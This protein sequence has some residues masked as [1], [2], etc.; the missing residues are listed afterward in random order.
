MLVVL[1][2]LTPANAAT[3]TV[4]GSGCDYNKVST[5]IAGVNAGDELDITDTG[6]YADDLAISK[7]ITIKGTGASKPKVSGKVTITAG[8][9]TLQFITFDP[10]AN[11][12]AITVSG[13]STTLH[14]HDSAVSNGGGSSG[15]NTPIGAGINSTA[16]TL[17]ISN[18]TFT[19]NICSTNVDDKGAHLYANGGSVTIS[20]STFQQAQAEYGAAI[21]LTG[22]ITGAI[23]TSTFA[24]NVAGVEAASIWCDATGTLTLT[25]DIFQSGTS[26]TD[27]AGHVF[28]SSAI[29]LTIDNATVDATAGSSIT[30]AVAGGFLRRTSSSGVTTV[31]G[32]TFRD[33]T[34]PKNGGAFNV[35]GGSDLDISGATF[36]TD[37]ASADGGDIWFSGGTLTIASSTFAGYASSTVDAANGGAILLSGATADISGSSFTNFDASASGG[38]IRA[39]SSSVITLTDTTFTSNHAGGDGGAISLV[40]SD[41]SGSG[42]TF[43]SNLADANGGAIHTNPG[44]VDLVDSL[45][46][47]NDGDAGGAVYITADTVARFVRDDFCENVASNGNGGA[48]AVAGNKAFT[49]VFRYST[50]VDNDVTKASAQGGAL[51]LAT[52]TPQLVGLDLVGN[53]TPSNGSGGGAYIGTGNNTTITDTLVAYNTGGP[54]LTITGT[55]SA[56]YLGFYNTPATNASPAALTSSLGSFVADPRLVAYTNGDGCAALAGDLWPD[57]PGSPLIDAGDPAILDPDGTRADIGT[58]GGAVAEARPEPWVD[59]DNDGWPL[60]SDCDDA[61]AGSFP[62]AMYPDTDGDG[63]GDDGA[64]ADFGCSGTPGYVADHTDCDD[65]KAAVNPNATE[66]CDASNTDEDCDGLADDASAT[67]KTTFYRDQDGDTYGLTGTTQ[68]ACD[69]PAGYVATSGDCNDGSA[70]IHPGATETCNGSDDDCDGQTDESDA[71]DA[72]TWHQDSDGDGF[73]GTVTQ[74]ACNRPSGYVADATDC[75]DTNAARNTG[76]PELCSTAFDDDCNGQI[77]EATA[78]D[79]PTWYKDLDNDTYGT[80][81]NTRVQCTLPSGYVAI[82]GDC[83]DSKSGVHPGA[84]ETCNNVDDNCDGQTDEGLRLTYYDDNDNDGFGDP[85]LPTAACSQP[86][87]FVSNNLDCDDT[88]ASINPNGT[89]TCD[90]R[91]QDCDGTID[92]GLAVTYYRDSDVDGFGNPNDSMYVCA[93]PNGY[94]AD[95]TDCDDTTSTIHPG[96]TETCNGVDND[97]DGQGGPNWDNDGDGH[98]WTDEVA[99]GSSDCSTDSDNDGIAD[100]VEWGG[101]ATAA[102]TDSDGDADVDDTDDDDDGVLTQDEVVGD[103]DN[104]GTVDRLDDD[105]DG[106]GHPTLEELARGD[107]DADGT[108]DYLDTDDDDDGQLTVDEHGDTDGDGADDFLDTDDDGDTLSTVDELAYGMDPVSTDSDQDGVD[109]AAEWGSDLYPRDSD[110]DGF[111]DALDPDDDEDGIPTFDEGLADFDCPDPDGTPA[112]LDLDSDGDGTPDAVEGTADQDFDGVPNYLDCLDTDGGTGDTDNDGL[113]NNEERDLGISG[114]DPDI[115]NDGI[116]DGVEVGSDHAN[117]QD[118]DNDGVW[119]VLDTDDDDDGVLTIDENY[120]QDTDQDGTEDA[121]D[122]DDDGDGVDTLVEGTG[123]YD[124]DGIPN[125][126]DPNDGDGPLGD[127]DGDGVSGGDE[128]AAGS[129][130]ELADSDGDGIPDGTEFGDD[131][132]H[133]RDT[134]LD[135]TPDVLDTDDDDDGVD[136]IDE[137]GFD[138]D[139]DGEPNNVDLD[140]DGDGIPDADE[141]LDDADCDGQPDF[142]DTDMPPCDDAPDTDLTGVMPPRPKVCATGPGNPGAAAMFLLALILAARRRR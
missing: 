139:G 12:S 18:T 91:D 68:S 101:G 59:G 11:V 49:S 29:D 47:S 36:D 126:L 7:N 125:Y 94:V 130:P 131:H 89:E 75:D 61:D 133:P 111:I 87:G 63:F 112:Y 51:H 83:D 97:C 118:T 77:N 136:S 34:L 71:S 21:Y 44:D 142:L 93:R 115:D 102:D 98:T 140:S 5:G 37:D 79:A 41:V 123:D 52:T 66:V 132:A 20:G 48:V 27:K 105:D 8:N 117:P 141:G 81:S 56:S 121:Y 39:I 69:A 73:G 17:D 96:A 46:A 100:A 84:T 107:S 99:A 74:R 6:T 138:A 70:A 14:L 33:L 85:N 16:A 122:T 23:D 113:T 103:S 129:D 13:G 88:R 32:G 60:I 109:D 30:G 114:Y 22:A 62:S 10:S 86:N 128:L 55:S 65:T 127:P 108:D 35:S 104:D 72:T 106:D 45:F 19:A 53:S 42:A 54:A 135:G 90:G 28:V 24:S 64:A 2:L 58:Y 4:C 40:S 116:L 82:S 124:G 15:N 119:D 50:F 38:A 134:D 1:A 78:T 76:M 120:P 110:T 25:D 3:K 31:T 80:T 67:G 92:E 137:G 57:Y 95:G 26:Q 9:V 43:T